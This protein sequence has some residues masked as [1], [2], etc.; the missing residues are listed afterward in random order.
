[1]RKV[2]L[3]ASYAINKKKKTKIRRSSIDI[4]AKMQQI[5]KQNPSAISGD[6]RYT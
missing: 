4:K 2:V 1:M 6:E 3:K 5:P